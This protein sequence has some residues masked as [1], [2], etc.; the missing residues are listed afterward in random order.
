MSEK[1]KEINKVIE[2]YFKNNPFV[3][4]IP[5]KDLMPYFIKDGIFN[6]DEKNGLPIRKLLRQLDAI[7]QLVQI[8]YVIAERKAI[9][10]NW[11]FGNTKN[12]NVIP[13]KA[14]EKTVKV[15]VKVS[16]TTSRKDSD[17][18]YII[19]LFDNVLKSVGSRQHTFDFLLGDISKKTGRQKKLPIDVYYESLK[20]V[21]EFNEQQHTKTVKH[22]DKPDIL[23][24]SGV[25]RGEQRK[26]Y[27]ARKRTELS[28]NK[29]NVIDISYKMFNY[30]RKGKI[31]RD[32]NKDIEIVKQ[33][34]NDYIKNKE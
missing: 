29:I 16:K 22:F 18:H 4:I 23:T 12:A 26:I 21:V 13:V 6:K 5:A 2:D 15:K 14:K 28:K 20:L 9:N 7:N 10:I 19:D 31:I 27:D 17:E 3:E 32:R 30:N 11:F 24:V 8:P 25:S 1:I 34:L 33:C